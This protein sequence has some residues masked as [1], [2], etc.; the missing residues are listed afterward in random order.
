MVTLGPPVG[1]FSSLNVR[2]L[3]PFIVTVRAP[4]VNVAIQVPLS[5]TVTSVKGW[6]VGLTVFVVQASP[7]GCGV[8]EQAG[9]VIVPP[10]PSAIEVP[11]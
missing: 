2:A 9:H 10:H 6:L 3:G 11:H 7:D 5:V 1:V 8:G 4:L